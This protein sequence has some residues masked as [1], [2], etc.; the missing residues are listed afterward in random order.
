VF[1]SK[2]LEEKLREG[3]G[4]SAMATVL[5]EKDGVHMQNSGLR[6]NNG[7]IGGTD[8]TRLHY[9]LRVEPEGEAPFEVKVDIR[10]DQLKVNRWRLGPTVP[11]LYDPRDHAKVA[12]DTAAMQASG[13][14][15][16]HHIESLADI[17]PAL[18]S[19]LQPVPVPGNELEQL[20]ELADL[21][22]RGALTDAEFEAGKA[23]LL[24]DVSL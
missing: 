8:I 20:K 24:R 4:K 1:G 21:H 14:G 16:R 13:Q 12:F 3:N 6:N 23:R 19:R 17:P 2:S 7:G 9:T 5:S 10:A 22:D 18:R 15:R 11:V